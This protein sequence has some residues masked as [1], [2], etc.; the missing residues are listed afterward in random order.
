MEWL[1]PLVGAIAA[2]AA[3]PALVLLYFLKLKRQDVPVSSTLLWKRAVQDLQVNAPFQRLRRNILLLLQLLALGAVLLA[4]AQPVLSLRAAAGKRL[5]LLLDRSASMSAADA[6]GG[7]ARLAEAK[8]QAKVLIESMRGPG[9]LALGAKGDEAMVLA[10]DSH[11]KVMCNFTSNKAQLAAAVDAVAP[12]DGGSALGEAV[13]VAR[14]F[15]QTSG[16]SENNRSA[17]T[18]AQLELFSDGRIED[19]AGLSMAPGELRFHRLGESRDNVAVVAMQARRSYDNADE[20]HV[21]ATLANY[22]DKPADCDVQ[23]SIDSIVRSVRR[24]TVPPTAPAEGD[25][26]E[27]L[28]KA[29]LSFVLTHASQGVV[30]VRQLRKD[31]LAGD[32]A[33]WTILPPPQK[34]SAL[35]VTRGNAPLEIAL[36]ACS[37][38]R[39]DTA[40]PA[41]FDAVVANDAPAPPYDLIVLDAHAPAK[42]PRGR[43][44]I[45][46]E[47]PP[48][49]DVRTA[50]LLKNQFIVDWRGRH[51]VLQ[52]VN[53]N[54]MYVAEAVNMKL[55]RDASVLAEFASSPAIAVVR[56][57]G[58]AF[59]LVGFDVLATRWP[60][61]SGFVMFCYN[62]ANF[63]GL[64]AGREKPADMKVGEAIDVQA[65]G[66]PFA[67]LTRPDGAIE[68][69][70]AEASGAFRYPAT[71]RV[72]VYRIDLPGR[73][74][75]LLAVNLLD[76]GES[77]IAPSNRI[78]LATGAVNAMATAPRRT[79][80][81]LWPY[82]A[83]A[84]LV[85]VCLEWIVYNSKARL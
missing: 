15:A 33:A 20:V 60:L 80:Q 38:A 40:T 70:A 54:E 81:D 16:I 56:R 3:V 27:T 12:T 57:R 67:T 39:L 6:P 84:A 45:F 22:A 29:S 82:L 69:L 44:L 23:L 47:P 46:G 48:D 73:P 41:A 65:D 11:A 9:L 52:F 49:I 35:L 32:D 85:L 63:M 14:A 68:R 53:L 74:A 31:A 50:G 13:T 17:A 7:S 24:V 77:N 55:P 34:L 26:G 78:V 64:E 37:L 66:Q 36:K 2:A 25:K 10:F 8:K 19:L 79:N 21:F 76:E 83:L 5:V 51:P 71:D 58:G 43:Y 30:E 75:T 28:G 18:A 4:I 61:E 62:A 59:L 1:T 72:G 42:L